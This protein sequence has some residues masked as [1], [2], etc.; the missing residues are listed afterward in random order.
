MAMSRARERA[1][2]VV[3]AGLLASVALIGEV[4]AAADSQQAFPRTLY[5]VRHGAYVPDRNADPQAG[6]GLTPL[7]VA[8]A[9]LIA[10]RLSGSGIA[11][12][13]MTSSTLQRARDTAAVMHETLTSVPLTQSPLLSECTPPL[14]ESAQGDAA[15]ERADCAKQLDQAFA[16]FFTASKGAKRN[17]ILVAHGNVIRY[18]VVRALNVDPRSWFGM[19]VAHASLTEIVVQPDGSLKVLAVGD[20]G[21]I[22]R[23]LLSWGDANDRQLVVPGGR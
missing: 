5:L 17:D 11:F 4:A 15:R 20:S 7:G 3:G 10:A 23:P 19:S 16:Q 8:Q 6:P 14:P 9:R 13:S 1:I 18:L 22:P 2:A 12:D 21:H